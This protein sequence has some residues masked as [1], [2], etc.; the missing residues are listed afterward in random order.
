VTHVTVVSD[1]AHLAGP[2]A[3]WIALE[4][5]AAIR[6]RGTCALG[7]SGGRT[8][9]PVYRELAGA[10]D[11]DWTRVSV[12]FGDERAVPPDDP[13]SNYR[14]VRETLLDAAGVP[15]ANVHRLR[16]EAP[17]LDAAASDYEAE[18]TAGAAPP[19]LDLVLLG[20]GTDGHTASLFPGTAGLR[21]QRRLCVAV[22]VPQHGSR[23]LTLTFPALLGA[24][25]VLFL[26]TGGDKAQALRDAI[27]GPEGGVDRPAQ[28]VMRRPGPV[29]V[30]CDREAAALLPPEF[31][32][33]A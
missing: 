23:R 6:E 33:G 32:G 21:E 4:T 8:P 5:T 18:L 16:G 12:F 2:V 22:D 3:R 31:T 10:H 26:V 19:W 24:R 11:I 7:L 9:E 17:E 25:D 15:A 28:H 1:A 27:A 30:M 14:M 13:E 29:V 20:M